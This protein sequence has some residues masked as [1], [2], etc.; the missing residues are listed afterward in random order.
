MK[1]QTR[2]STSEDGA[3]DYVTLF[4]GSSIDH[5]YS[6]VVDNNQNIYVAGFTS[7][8]DFPVT[9]N[10]YNTT[11]SSKPRDVFLAKLSPDGSELLFA[12]FLFGT[13]DDMF[14][15]S[16]VVLV[17]DS[18]NNPIVVGATT[19]TTF[20]TTTNAYSNSTSGNNDIVI[21][22]LT[23]NG[24]SLIYGSYLGGSGHEDIY[25]IDIDDD[26][27][28]YLV[29]STTSPDFPTT[30]GAYQRT[31]TGQTD[32]FVTKFSAN[33]SILEYSTYFG[34]TGAESI[35]SIAV[36]SQKN[37]WVAGTT[38]STDL[39]VTVDAFNTSSNGGATINFDGFLSGQDTFIFKLSTNG[40]QLL[41][42][43]YLGGSDSDV[44]EW[45]DIDSNDNPIIAIL[46]KSNDFPVTPDALYPTSSGS[47]WKSAITKIAADGSSILY[48]TYFGG[49][50][51]TFIR[52]FTLDSNDNIYVTGN[53]G[54]NSF[55]ITGDAFDTTRVFDDGFF[56][57]IAANG[58]ELLYSTFLGGNTS[59]WSW[60]ISLSGDNS[61]YIGGMTS[62]KTHPFV[63]T[64]YQNASK[65]THNGFYNAFVVK[66]NN[67]FG[68]SVTTTTTPT[69]GVDGFTFWM[70]GLGFVML[71]TVYL[72]RKKK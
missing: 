49:E 48:S 20:G 17:L 26:D 61:I 24:T 60:T 18:S 9:A 34:G 19:A 71:G 47:T 66:F 39:P 10:A 36:D 55:P 64:Y 68:S 42:A 43:S 56:S 50:E 29:G 16:Q 22:K 28:L 4:G 1:Q 57:V 72:K 7:S 65:I 35:P 32:V 11:K 38:G 12:T 70:V 23:P 8:E 6:S 3:I 30:P 45:I 21:A 53:T 59:E 44:E 62:S 31:F 41:Y 69:P 13:N 33:G 40:S 46:T 58:N 37:V 51:N 52:A 63:D 14:V 25:S 54:S 15:G 27:N 67:N 5:V 2:M